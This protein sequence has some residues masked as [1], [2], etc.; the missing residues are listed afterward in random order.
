VRAIFAILVVIV[1]PLLWIAIVVPLLARF[2]GIPTKVGALPVEKRNPRMS[3]RQS[4]W[5]AGA[6]GWG[7][8]ISL[9]GNLGARLLDGRRPTIFQNLF[10][11]VLIVSYWGLLN[12]GGWT[13]P[14]DE[15]GKKTGFG[16][17]GTPGLRQNH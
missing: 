2:T 3:E 16:K 12:Q 14:I 10:G 5:F 13:Y 1:C 17:P 15:V 11:F 4:F 6:L 8:G 7:V 9:L